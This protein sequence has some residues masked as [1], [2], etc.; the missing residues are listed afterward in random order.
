MQLLSQT[1]SNYLIKD[2]IRP[3]IKDGSD[4][5]EIRVFLAS[6]TPEI[7]Y[8]TGRDLTNYL[9]GQNKGIEF[10][11]KIGANLW[12]EWRKEPYPAQLLS[13]IENA[14]WVDNQDRM[15]HYR[16][17]KW[18]DTSAQD[19]LIVILIGVDQ[20]TDQGSLA[21]FYQVNVSVL[22]KRALKRSFRSW[23]EQILNQKKIEAEKEHTDQINELLKLLYN[24]S[25]GDLLRIA[26]FLEDTDF[27]GAQDG[28]DA[29]DILYN[30]LSFWDLPLLSEMKTRGKR[31]KY[32]QKAID[33]FSYQPF[34]K[35]S[36]RKR[37]LKK[38]D[39]Y[40]EKVDQGDESS[41]YLTKT[42]KDFDDFIN[43]L[44]T[45][46]DKNTP[47]DREK[48]LNFNFAV[49]NDKIL[50]FRDKS[51]KKDKEKP[52]PIR[53][54]IGYPLEIILTAIWR[55][56]TDYKHEADKQKIQPGDALSGIRLEP[57]MFYHDADENEDGFDLLTGIIG[58]I[59][60]FLEKEIALAHKTDEG[61][62]E[63]QL[64]SVLLNPDKMKKAGMSIPNFQFRV[65]IDALNDAGIQRTYK[66][67]VPETHTHRMLWNFAKQVADGIQGACLPIFGIRYYHELFSAPDEEEC[68]RILKHG[69]AE[70]KIDNLLEA[71]GLNKNSPYW[72][73]IG[74]LNRAF[75]D[76]LN[77]WVNKGF[78]KAIE[79]PRSAFF[80]EMKGILEAFV[81]DQSDN[82]LPEYAPIIYKAFLITDGY[83]EQGK[84]WYWEPGVNSAVVSGLHP[85]LLE[86]LKHRKTFLIHGFTELAEELLGDA[87]QKKF[88]NQKWGHICDQAAL[89]YPLF[90]L[91]G[92]R[93]KILDT[94]VESMGL[95]HRIG[96]PPEKETTLSAK[97]LQRY[98][99]PEDEEIDDSELFRET[100][101]SR[102]IKNI[103]KEFVKL[104]PHAEDGLSIVILNTEN[105]QPVIAGI[106]R[107]LKAQL[108][109]VEKGEDD[110]FPPYHFSLMVFVRPF[111][112][113]DI[114]HWLQQW[115]KRWE[116][117]QLAD[118]LKHYQQCRISLA[119]RVI[120][121]ITDYQLVFKKD[122]FDTDIA[123]LA[124]FMG[125]QEGDVEK[126]APYQTD[127]ISMLKF[128][129][130]E[131]PRCMEEHP[132]R[133]Y[134]RAR[135]ISNRRFTIAKLH[136]E[137]SARMM[138]PG[139]S[140]G[141]EYI[142]IN[143]SDYTPWTEV[144]DL[145]H[146][147]AS[148]VVCMDP[149]I[150]E[151]LI[152]QDDN[153]NWKREIIGFS[154]GVGAHGEL[155]YT[156]STERA[157]IA[158]IQERIQHQINRIF[159]P[160]EPDELEKA[161]K[162]LVNESRKLSGLSLVRATGPN[163]FVRDLI[164]YALIRI[165][166]PR[167]TSDC[168][169]LCDE[170]IGLDAFQHWFDNADDQ[171]RPDLMHITAL[172][173]NSGLIRINAHLIEC[174]VAKE[175]TVHQ[176]KARIQLENGLRQLASLFRP[177]SSE[178]RF[179]ERFWWAQLQRLIAS[180]S[181]V[182]SNQQTQATEALEKLGDGVFE[183]QWHASAVTFWTDSGQE[184]F[185]TETQWT[186]YDVSTQKETPIT[187][188][189][190]G[191]GLV[192]KVCCHNEI[193]PLPLDMENRWIQPLSDQIELNEEI[194]IVEEPE[195][196][197]K[198]SVVSNEVLKQEG[199]KDEAALDQE[200]SVANVQGGTFESNEPVESQ[201]IVSLSDRQ[202]PERIFLG[203]T[204]SAKREIFWEFGHDGLSNR[205]LLIFGK[206]GSGKTY[207]IQTILFEL[208]RQKQHSVI[209]DYTNGFLQKHLENVF[210]ET[211]KPLPH[212]V[213]QKPLPINPF[214]IQQQVIDENID[215]I[216]EDPHT[217]AGRITSVFTAVYSSF[218]EQQKATLIKTIR[219]GVAGSG[220][221]YS[222]ENLLQ[223]L[224]N[225][226]S[227]G[228]G[229]ANKISP[230]VHSHLFGGEDE[231]SWRELYHESRHLVNIMQLAGVPRDIAQITTEFALWDLYNYATNN[232][233]KNIPLPIVLDEIQN[234]DHRLD[235]PLGKMLTEGRKF[236]LSL[237]LATQTLSNLKAEEK[238]RLFQAGHKLFFKPADT[239]VQ[240]YAKILERATK[241]KADI[242]MGRLTSLSK[243]E[244]YSLGPALNP[245]SGK[246]EDKAFHIKITSFEERN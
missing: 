6:F 3:M 166:S 77:A 67:Q 11:Y 65:I 228:V 217:V 44:K 146:Q 88:T 84:N 113:R 40:V 204:K 108:G 134:Y 103:L 132:S 151:R 144:I 15:T 93:G 194:T 168:L 80:K 241:E 81:S 31:T 42:F 234:L 101:E 43:V 46:I 205:H 92:R 245:R 227:A 199:L 237:L 176:D 74:D 7:I 182:S 243:G 58:G 85:A 30:A 180:K 206:S 147:H 181:I 73:M 185:K 121:N 105:I 18:Q 216:Q 25:T 64:T 33:F 135:V 55:T 197:P 220:S 122:H 230:M 14:E 160:W 125:N 165:C 47:D 142:V 223:D 59:D 159:G 174:K 53:T 202:I 102:V 167:L 90:G 131:A 117:S 123:L 239:E 225:L 163:E 229:I 126:A 50:E 76:L 120:K 222:F 20:A 104:H 198:P 89:H 244:C 152:G 171:H 72:G 48:L 68:N 29:L 49:I 203:L 133:R 4:I 118:K 219:E 36:A 193:I 57:I 56:L 221:E 52:P 209:I 16:N 9:A 196:D 37:A 208:A 195:H 226:G 75:G 177:K 41:P 213:R 155:N 128:P 109:D 242:W 149:V 91:L 83:N 124:R 184:N 17:L 87:T 235:S 238:D 169:C 207:A 23:I 150:D 175:N 172:L 179:D 54:L 111:Q 79:A 154:S 212:V 178:D 158:D 186:Y 95:L 19:G 130:L 161:S 201:A 22:W 69:L 210:Q 10:V 140:Q 39:Q 138:H 62:Q 190:C 28:I 156:I 232:G 35:E 137:L 173:D 1:L 97:I 98:D 153:E 26:E 211:V 191:A 115:R 51:Q 183:I 148:W 114:A 200:S 236:G 145:L 187:V 45:Y 192:K 164:A 162:I 66:W 27:K 13:D 224:E 189:T 110:L 143:E 106:D 61:E 157:S 63:I 188:F 119:H 218:G 100:R 141:A 116:P 34:L 78:F 8:Q 231:N 21:D 170:I 2:I 38:V 129:I 32:V 215:P 94:R 71:P 99:A 12:R 107:F 24:Q 240:E 127:W 70:L 86:M 246:L 60:E 136:S 233:S 214:Q 82:G 96:K 112:S 5:R 139:I